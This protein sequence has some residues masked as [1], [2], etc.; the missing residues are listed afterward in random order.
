[1][2]IICDSMKLEVGIEHEKDGIDAASCYTKLYV[3]NINEFRK[4][5]FMNISFA[6]F[7]E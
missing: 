2:M 5:H 1:M 4:K 7:F 6:Y 3:Y